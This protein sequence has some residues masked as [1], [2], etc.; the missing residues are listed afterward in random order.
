MKKDRHAG[1]QGGK[2]DKLQGR[3]GIIP[4][5]WKTGR[6]ERQVTRKSEKRQ[7]CWKTWRKERQVIGKGRNK[8]GIVKDKEERETSS[9]ER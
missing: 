6:K 4:A 1:R 8:T 3:V 5:W 2:R 7:A 9:R